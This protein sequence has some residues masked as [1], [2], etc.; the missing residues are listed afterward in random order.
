M[1]IPFIISTIAGLST[2]LGAL[3]IFI[4]IKEE[5]INKFITFSLA[6]SLSVMISVSVIELIP[7]SLTIFSTNYSFLKGFILASIPFLC[8]YILIRII[9]KY[10]KV[11]E[12]SKLLKLGVLSSLALFLHNLPEGIATFMSA[13]YDINLGITLGIAIMLHNIPEGIAIAVPIYYATGDRKKAIKYTLLSG[14][15]EPIGSLL[16]YIVLH[17]YINDVLISIVLLVVAGIMITL[18]IEEMFPASKKYNCDKN[19]S[20][21]LIVGVVLVLLTHFILG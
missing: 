10:T 14:L 12:G 21:G 2:L 13:Y 6:M 3:V 9:S 15:S 11:G 17:K 1:L 18:S 4:K 20:I 16:A 8:G 19:L 7:D 5:N